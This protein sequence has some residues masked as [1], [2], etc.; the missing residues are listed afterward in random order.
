[1]FSSLLDSCTSPFFQI[2]KYSM[3]YK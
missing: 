3:Q 2:W 1:L